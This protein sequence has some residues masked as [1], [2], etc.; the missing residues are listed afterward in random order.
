MVKKIFVSVGMR[1]REDVEVLKDLNRA[2]RIL[3][4]VYPKQSFTVVDNWATKGP[5][6]A[7]RL[8]YLGEAIKRLGDCEACFFVK[9][10]ENYKGCRIEMEVCKQ[11]GI[12]IL[13]ET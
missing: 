11:Y 9:G 13:E 6:D 8:W 5:E 12:E 2:I 3:S 7:G 10:W 1:G 4:S